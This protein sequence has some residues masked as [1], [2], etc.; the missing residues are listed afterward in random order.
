MRS[1][2]FLSPTFF[3][4]AA[5][6]LEARSLDAF[7]ELLALALELVELGLQ[8]LKVHLRWLTGLLSRRIEEA[9]CTVS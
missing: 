2:M 5:Y 9:N 8:G 1:S 6:C 3:G 4:R 7:F